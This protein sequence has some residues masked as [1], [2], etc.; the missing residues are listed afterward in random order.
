MFQPFAWAAARKDDKPPAYSPATP[1]PVVRR[2]SRLFIYISRRSIG[3]RLTQIHAEHAMLQ[4]S[5]IA[6]PAL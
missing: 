6:D 1:N 3:R 5:D 4:S 2:N